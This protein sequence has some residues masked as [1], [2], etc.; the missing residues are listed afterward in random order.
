MK[1][2][3]LNNLEWFYRLCCQPSRIGRMMKLPK[4]VF[5]TVLYRLSG[6]CKRTDN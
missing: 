1:Q 4:F 3:L 5:G 2:L 6:N